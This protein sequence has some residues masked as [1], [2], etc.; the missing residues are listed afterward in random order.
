MKNCFPYSWSPKDP[1]RIAIALVFFL[2]CRIAVQAQAVTDFKKQYA[3]LAANRSLND[4]ERLHK[5]F[6]LDW[7]RGLQE[8]PESATSLGD[9]RF[10]DRWTDMSQAAID[11]RNAELQW[12]LSV[13]NSINRAKLSKAD[14]LNFDLYKRD[15]DIALEGT[16]FPGELLQISQLGGVHQSVPQV[17][18]QMPTNSVKAYEN[19]LARL[20]KVPLLVDQTTELL[21]RG[22]KQGE[23]TPK[24]ILQAV[25]KQILDVIPEEPLKSEL[26]KPFTKFPQSIPQ[27][28]QKRLKDEAVKIYQEQL[29]PAF[30]K[31]HDF[32]SSEYLPGARETTG[33]DTLP[34][35]AN[36]YA[37][38]ARV[39]TTTT[40]SPQAI[41]ELGLR[42]VKRIRAEMEKVVAEVKFKG[43]FDEFTRFLRTDP[44]FY[45][46]DP[47][48]LLAGYRDIA[49]R[50]D[51][52]LSR[53][54][55]K[56]PR[57]T[58]GVK[59]IPA[60]SENS[61]PDAYYEGG[62]KKAGRPGWFLANTSNLPSRPKWEMEVLTLHEAVPGHHLQISLA[63]EMTGRPEFRKYEGYT[64]Y[65]EGWALY[66]EGLGSE[67]G[68]YEDPYSKFGMWK[69][70]M[71]RAVRLVVDTGMHAFGWSREKAIEYM[72]SNTGGDEHSSTVEIDRYIVSPGQA[73]SYKIGQLKIR[74]LR[75][76]AERELGSAFDIRRF[77]DVLLASGALPLDVLESS[78]RDWIAAEKKT[79][80]HP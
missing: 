72:M 24:V 52:E 78:L 4:T 53:L 74:E 79:N 1:F 65:V 8:S 76:E 39:Y 48:A 14:Q 49:K 63:Q 37:Y 60:Y 54:F 67:L 44:Q 2:F 31:F 56:L 36:W 43:S 55:G 26:L 32:V 66:C 50:I 45:Y 51:P 69:F 29:A 19:V 41:H 42:E 6:D 62:S 9:N 10:D 58:Y 61:A 35:G 22:L 70:E 68:M 18:I 7:E 33:W 80:H 77:H 15:L 40:M 3:D 20:R 23:T 27:E 46:S 64:A 12:P 16:Q 38:N 13:I 59:A 21:R 47:K 75:S 25:P 28:E 57:L 17:L 5:L 30:R 71:W 34:N 11:A 73:L